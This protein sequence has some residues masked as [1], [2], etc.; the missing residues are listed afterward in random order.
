MKKNYIA[1]M[2]TS[3]GDAKELTQGSGSASRSDQIIVN[4]EP[5]NFGGGTFGSNDLIIETN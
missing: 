3:F 4:G 1:P 2:L 5:Q